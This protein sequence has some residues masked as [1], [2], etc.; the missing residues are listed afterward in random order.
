MSLKHGG[1]HYHSRPGYKQG[2]V[3]NKLATT[4]HASKLLM[5]INC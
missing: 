2:H 4:L 1:D 3:L 5:L